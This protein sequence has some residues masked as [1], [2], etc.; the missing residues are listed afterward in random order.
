[1]AHLTE[2]LYLIIGI[3]GEF[4]PN[5]ASLL[6]ETVADAV[7]HAPER[8]GMPTPW[9]PCDSG[10]DVTTKGSSILRAWNHVDLRRSDDDRV[11]DDVPASGLFRTTWDSL[12]IFGSIALASV[13]MIAPARCAGPGL[14]RRVASSV[15]RPSER[16]SSAAT[17]TI[18]EVTSARAEEKRV[19]WDYGSVIA[20]MRNLYTLDVSLYEPRRISR[21]ASIPGDLFDLHD[22]DPFGL[23]VSL[24]EWSV[25]DAA[26]LVEAVLGACSHAGITE[27]VLVTARAVE[28]RALA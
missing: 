17:P 3:R 25:D 16:H 20:A 22:P 1:V 11:P 13:D 10:V 14:C 24:P 28:S 6:P 27:D 18:V 9:G 23:E 15:L 8:W 26:W 7:S 12:E 19:G 5:T 2:N 21:S 4:V